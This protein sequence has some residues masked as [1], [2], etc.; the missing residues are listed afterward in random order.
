MLLKKQKCK[1]RDIA[2]FSNSKANILQI[3]VINKQFL[4]I[5]AHDIVLIVPHWGPLLSEDFPQAFALYCSSGGLFHQEVAPIFHFTEC[6]NKRGGPEH[7]I[8][9]GWGREGPKIFEG[10]Q[11]S[12][13]EGH[14]NPFFDGYCFILLKNVAFVA[15]PHVPCSSAP[16]Q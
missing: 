6:N 16:E 9:G 1:I 14:N 12:R 7:F 5:F 10:R 2:N 15:A 11:I 4:I 8:W 3:G 13:V